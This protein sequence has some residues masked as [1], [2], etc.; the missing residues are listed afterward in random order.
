MNIKNVCNSIASLGK[1]NEAFF[2]EIKE[3]LQKIFYQELVRCQV[4]AF[5]A[6]E[7]LREM[8]NNSL[9]FNKFSIFLNNLNKMWNI[10]INL[11]VKIEIIKIIKI[12]IGRSKNV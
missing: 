6:F 12:I 7:S 8:F 10:S 2:M 5:E 3:S 11:H 1:R 9:I 4:Y